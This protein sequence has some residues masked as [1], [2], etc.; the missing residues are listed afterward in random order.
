MQTLLPTGNINMANLQPVVLCGGQSTRMG[1]DKGLI[2]SG[3]ITWV[4]KSLE[5]LL[6]IGKVPL[7]S[8]NP[9]QLPLYSTIISQTQ[10]IAD[11]PTIEV[12]GPLL[13]VLTVHEQY[14]DRDLLLLACDL[15]LMN[16][17]VIKILTN[18]YIRNPGYEAYIFRNDNEPEP[19]CSIYTATG[20]R[21]VNNNYRKGDLQKHS[22]KNM[23][24]MLS[25]FFIDVPFEL[26]DCFR[27]FNSQSEHP[28]R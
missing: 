1:T 14:P 20:L 27:N 22:M 26:K 19:L 5:L 17:D 13:G 16:L 12:K 23:I 8:V 3:S 28:V 7:V 2:K 15:L 25:T 11:N 6:S 24:S 21:I 9:Q 4:E 18:N 10:L